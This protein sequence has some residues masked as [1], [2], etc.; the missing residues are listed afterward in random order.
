MVVAEAM[1][2]YPHDVAAALKW[3]QRQRRPRT[4]RVARASRRNG[5]I[6]HLSGP[7]AAARNLVLRRVPAQRLMARY[8][9]L[10]GW[11]CE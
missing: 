2:R 5:R 9:W 8:D 10:Y 11:R 1:R 7:Q 4:L 3:Y 6:F